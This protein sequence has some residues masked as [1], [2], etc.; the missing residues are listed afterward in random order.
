MLLFRKNEILNT[1]NFRPR[2][3][4]LCDKPLLDKSNPVLD[5]IKRKFKESN[6]LCG[7]AMVGVS[8]L[9]P[10]Q[11]VSGDSLHIEVSQVQKTDYIFS[12][13]FMIL[14]TPPTV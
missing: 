3:F 4:K 7:L 11:V 12:I 8:I 14:Q 9:W 5:Q 6:K 2:K 13:K 1:E 10:G